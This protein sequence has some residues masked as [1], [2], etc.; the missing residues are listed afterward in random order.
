MDNILEPE[1]TIIME[2]GFG[3]PAMAREIIALRERLAELKAQ[4][5]NFKCLLTEAM[6]HLNE[7]VD[8]FRSD[9]E[10]E[11]VSI[12]IHFTRHQADMM[13]ENIKIYM[14]QIK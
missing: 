6:P 9:G 12:N 3:R 2:F 8:A 14:E 7:M 4:T 10:L 5:D 11:D 13:R 1:Y